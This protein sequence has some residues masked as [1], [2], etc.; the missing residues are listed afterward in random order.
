MKHVMSNIFSRRKALQAGFGVSAGLLLPTLGL[1]AS[2]SKS[3]TGKIVNNNYASIAKHGNFRNEDLTLW[4]L[5]ELDNANQLRGVLTSARQSFD[6]R[7]KIK[8][9]SNDK[10]KIEICKHLIDKV[11]TH[12]KVKFKMLVFEGY[13]ASIQDASP[14]KIDE[15]LVSFYSQLSANVTNEI[16]IKASDAFGPS[17]L[18]NDSVNTAGGFN[19]TANRTYEDDLIQLND[20]ISGLV[21]AIYRKVE[22]HSNT[23][24]ELI[25]YFKKVYNLEGGLQVGTLGNNITFD[26]GK[27]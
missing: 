20:L 26:K 19:L 22:V 8:Y 10:F 4:S 15:R 1:R 7:A 21:Y 23:K 6:Y 12:N 5:M 14:A 25:D 2:S 9:S 3:A 16:F 18:F 11:A 13:A 24:L 27:I 17:E